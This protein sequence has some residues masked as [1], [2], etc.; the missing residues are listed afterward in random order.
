MVFVGDIMLDRGTRTTI[1]KY[2]TDYLF[3]D[4]KSIF[5]E[6]DFTIANFESTACDTSLLPQ[7]KLYTFRARAEWISALPRN[8]VTHVSVANNHS[9]DYGEEGFRQ[10]I[11]N[12]KSSG[13]NLLTYCD[14]IP[15]V[16]ENGGSRI[17]I[18]ST[19]FLA[20]SSC[21][22]CG[23]D[24]VSLIRHIKNYKAVNPATLVVVFIHWG[25]EMQ[26]IPTARQV[27]QAHEIVDAGADAIVGHHPHVVQTLEVFKGRYIFYSLGNFIFDF[28]KAPGNK[29]LITQFSISNGSIQSVEAIPYSIRKSKPTPMDEASAEMFMQTIQQLSPTVKFKKNHG[30][31][32]VI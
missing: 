20:K 32:K 19:N 11:D 25:T 26:S 1:E 7:K 31:W 16:C 23:E 12:I 8:G 15:T 27:R 14:S 29:G 18:F 13:L 5:G 10:T 9:L 22:S 24:E 28:S 2:G 17:A 3:G 6:S 30:V 21:S 4:T